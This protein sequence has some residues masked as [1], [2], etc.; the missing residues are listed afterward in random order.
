[1]I[2]ESSVENEESSNVRHNVFSIRIQGAGKGF[3]A[4]RG[5]TEA[6]LSRLSYTF[7]R[8]D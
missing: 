2:F 5:I 4:V 1:M 6:Q 7:I 3:F 8:K